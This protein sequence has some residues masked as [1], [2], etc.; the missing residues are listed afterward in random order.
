MLDFV[1]VQ[2]DGYAYI[3]LSR[4]TRGQ[5]AALSEVQVNEYTD[6]HGKDARDVKRVKVKLADKRMALVDC[7]KHLGMFSE[8]VKHNHTGTVVLEM[9]IGERRA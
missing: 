1:T 5:A 2:N 8:K 7:G 9:H 3:D 4:L 6:G